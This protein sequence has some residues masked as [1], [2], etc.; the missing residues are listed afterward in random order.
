MSK[1]IVCILLF[2][3][4]SLNA[5]MAQAHQKG[6]TFTNAGIILGLREERFSDISSAVVGFVAMDYA[7]NDH[8]SVGGFVGKSLFNK[9]DGL[10]GI[11]NYLY[12]ARFGIHSGTMENFDPYINFTLGSVAFNTPFS[13]MSYKIYGINVGT[14]YFFIKNFGIFA[15]VGIGAGVL[16]FGLVDKF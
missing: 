6:N 7:I 5:V 14:R 11:S 3:I 4:I 15:D 16:S 8:L 1:K 9:E 12:A 2:F 10:F 13:G